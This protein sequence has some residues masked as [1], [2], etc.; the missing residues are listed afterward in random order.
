MVTVSVPLTVL[1]TAVL[2]AAFVLVFEKPNCPSILTPAPFVPML[3]EAPT[4]A[5]IDFE[6]AT[7]W[8]VSYPACNVT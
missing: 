6:L 1:S 8:V 2:D 3:A 7:S 5:E 4:L